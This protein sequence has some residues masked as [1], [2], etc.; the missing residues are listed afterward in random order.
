MNLNQFFHIARA[1]CAI[2]NTEYVTVFGA[3]AAL[4]WLKDSGIEDMRAFISSE[5]VSRELDLCVGDG[6]D[7]RLN[8]LID[9]AIGE[10]SQFDETFGIYAHP[11]P[12][13]GLFQAPSS[14]K[15]R[16]RIEKEPA[17]QIKIIVPHYLDLTVSKIIA[18]RTKDIEFALRAAEFFNIRIKEIEELAEEYVEEHPEKREE[19]LSKMII[20]KYKL[21]ILANRDR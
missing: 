21:E 13:E 15:T 2:A 3:N 1:S 8:T 14:W 12:I 7:N 19:V 20:F 16:I 11:N 18:G 4:L 10:I 5:N 17:S 9:G 6:K